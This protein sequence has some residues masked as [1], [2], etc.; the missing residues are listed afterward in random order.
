MPSDN[1]ASAGS[2]CR[3]RGSTRHSRLLRFKREDRFPIKETDCG[4]PVFVISS[5]FAM[6]KNVPEN[7][8]WSQNLSSTFPS[9]RA[10]C[11]AY[12]LFLMLPDETEAGACL[13][14]LFIWKRDPALMWQHCYILQCFPIHRLHLLPG[15]VTDI[16]VYL[17]TNFHFVK[18]HFIWTEFTAVNWAQLFSV[19]AFLS[20]ANQKNITSHRKVCDHFT[21]EE[22]INT[23]HVWKKKTGHFYMTVVRKESQSFHWWVDDVPTGRIPAGTS[24]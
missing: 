18:S 20:H 3:C 21:N 6:S 17:V 4:L 13:L 8:S 1:I 19:S 9:Q 23:Q 2:F 11:R 10:D 22:L 5:L 24:V 16:Q 15:Y 12:P 7:L 14:D